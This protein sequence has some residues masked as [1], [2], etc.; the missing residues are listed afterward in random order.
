M[1][2][3]VDVKTVF[4]VFLFLTVLVISVNF[5]RAG[6][7]GYGDSADLRYIVQDDSVI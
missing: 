2:K 3:E 7:Y 4:F 5:V 6:P 1:L